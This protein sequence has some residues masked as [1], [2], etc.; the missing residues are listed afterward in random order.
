MSI[1]KQEKKWSRIRKKGNRK[2][3]ECGKGYE[4]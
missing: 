4:K 3:R 2:G 1:K